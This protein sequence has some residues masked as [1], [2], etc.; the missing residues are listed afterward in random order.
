M[1]PRKVDATGRKLLFTMVGLG[2]AVGAL[3]PLVAWPFV[4]YKGATMTTVFVVLCL[5]AGT[6]MGAGAYAL[7]RKAS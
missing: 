6:G 1:G 3:F 2:L 7:A 4:Q 5:L